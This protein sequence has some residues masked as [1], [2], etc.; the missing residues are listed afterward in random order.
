MN[1]AGKY[2]QYVTIKRPVYTTDGDYGERVE[3]TTQTIASRWAEIKPLTG[4]ERD[5]AAR[6]AAEYQVALRT[7]LDLR[8]NDRL[9]WGSRTL[10]VFT[11]LETPRSGEMVV[12]CKELT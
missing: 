1:H 9:I 8:Q 6:V 4:N 7:P 5:Y 11:I 2:D 10:E 12:Q 3:S